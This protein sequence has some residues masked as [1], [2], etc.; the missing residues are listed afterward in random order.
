MSSS[1]AVLSVSRS[2]VI[3]FP[4][5]QVSALFPW[6]LFLEKGCLIKLWVCKT[7]WLEEELPG[8]KCVE[9]FEPEMELCQDLTTGIL[10]MFL[11]QAVSTD[12]PSPDSIFLQDL[13]SGFVPY[14][15]TSGT[16]WLVIHWGRSFSAFS[17]FDLPLIYFLYFILIYLEFFS[18]TWLRG[19]KPA[20]LQQYSLV[21]PF[22]LWFW[23][24]LCRCHDWR[25]SS[26]WGS[27]FKSF[28]SSCSCHQSLSEGD[29]ARA[30]I[31][32]WCLTQH[33]V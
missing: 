31:S 5:W 12:Y 33:D 8:W 1:M 17:C 25:H 2:R 26:T 15:M 22:W 6:N 32:S 30:R 10:Y 11:H 14:T 24:N 20:S 13:G 27:N 16:H 9:T 23:D 19:R 28:L 21:A 3:F 18:F 7:L 4:S 29:V